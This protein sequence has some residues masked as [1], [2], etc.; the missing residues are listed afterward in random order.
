MSDVEGK[1]EGQ[2]CRRCGKR[3]GNIQE[4]VTVFAKSTTALDNHDQ[5]VTT[6]IR[7]PIYVKTCLDCWHLLKPTPVKNLLYYLAVIIFVIVPFLYSLFILLTNWTELF[8]GSCLL[9]TMAG[10]GMLLV[11]IIWYFIV[12]GGIIKPSL[13][14]TPVPPERWF[15]E[16]DEIHK[17]ADEGFQPI[18]FLTIDPP[19]TPEMMYEFEGI[20]VPAK[21]DSEQSQAHA[22]TPGDTDATVSDSKISIDEVKPSVSGISEEPVPR[23]LRSSFNNFKSRCTVIEDYSD[24]I[25]EGIESPESAQQ[26]VR[27]GKSTREA[28]FILTK[29]FSVITESDFFSTVKPK[30]KIFHYPICK[31]CKHCHDYNITPSNRFHE[32]L[33]ILFIFLWILGSLLIM[34][35]GLLKWEF[36]VTRDHIAVVNSVVVFKMI[37]M[38]ILLSAVLGVTKW[39]ILPKNAKRINKP[40]RKKYQGWAQIIN[41]KLKGEW[42]PIYGAKL[43]KPM[44]TYENPL[45]FLDAFG[46]FEQE[47]GWLLQPVLSKDP[48]ATQFKSTIYEW[49]KES[50]LSAKSD[51]TEHK[52]ST[53]EFCLESTTDSV[54]ILLYR[55][56]LIV[57]K[58]QRGMF[59]DFC[60]VEI[61]VCKKCQVKHRKVFQRTNGQ[62]QVW[63]ALPWILSLL[64]LSIPL[65]FANIVKGNLNIEG[66]TGTLASLGIGL[67]FIL[68]YGFIAMMIVG[69]ILVAKDGD[70]RNPIPREK[71]IKKIRHIGII[72]DAFL[73]G[74]Q[75]VHKLK[76]DEWC[77][78]DRLKDFLMKFL[79]EQNAQRIRLL[80][81]NG[82]YVKSSK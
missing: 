36:W 39:F 37:A 79:K 28:H 82:K 27:C 6:I 17:L 2:I 52:D 22:E 58:N 54:D 3:D 78:T 5:L 15:P 75:P 53:C 68:L 61:P 66:S 34:G 65:Y 31:M 18:A 48:H 38:F 10:L 55:K 56:E 29:S 9:S 35:V 41:D 63:S 67:G 62:S 60:S 14:I 21:I 26:C 74:W 13:D 8:S 1:L 16:N 44:D 30:F 81:E 42:V 47:I 57:D 24:T 4:F 59:H 19:F 76:Y 73:D 25:V 80:D 12:T 49:P 72:R 71:R 23:T 77:I 51:E 69:S 7:R 40:V 64:G 20:H 33:S 46:S 50:V 45:A 43:R 70:I 11:F 32:P